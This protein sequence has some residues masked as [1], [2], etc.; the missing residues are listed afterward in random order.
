LR[1]RRSNQQ[2]TIRSATNRQ[3]L[4]VRILLRNQILSRRNEIIK[5]ILLLLQHARP[6]PVFPKFSPAAQVGHSKN[7][8]M[9]EPQITIAQKA[10]SQADVES[11]I[12]REHGRI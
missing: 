7:T 4:F 10:R 5:N 8:P 3:M 6:V 1:E 2:S 9:L 11:S 12:S